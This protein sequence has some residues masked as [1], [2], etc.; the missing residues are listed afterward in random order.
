MKVYGKTWLFFAGIYLK[1]EGRKHILKEGPFLICSNHSSFV[2]IPV[3]YSLFD[4]YFIFTGKQEIEKWPLFNI[5]YT[6]GMNI[7]VDRHDKVKAL[8]GFKRMMETVEGGSPLMVFPE[9]TISKT[10][11]KLTEFKIGAVLV[12]IKKQVPILPITFTTNW[13]RLQR[14]GLFEGEA[15]PGVA[16]VIV[17]PPISTEGLKKADAEELLMK[18]RTIINTP[19]KEKYGVE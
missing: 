12:A 14:K 11:P 1:V 10:A 8:K 15:S 17:H 3:L 4:D 13:K 9:G 2:D 5:F 16:K 6:S 18:L 19:L 7:L